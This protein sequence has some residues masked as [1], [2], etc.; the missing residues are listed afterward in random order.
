MLLCGIAA[1]AG[2]A[3]I[4]VAGEFPVVPQQRTSLL[5]VTQVRAEPASMSTYD[6]EPEIRVGT[7]F[8]RKLPIPS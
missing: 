1:E 4:S 6:D 3:V 7:F 2:A 8:A 5:V